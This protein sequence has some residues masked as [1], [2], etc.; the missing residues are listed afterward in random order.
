MSQSPF[1][2]N[3]STI[4][5][6]AQD[7]EDSFWKNLHSETTTT[8]Q[9]LRKRVEPAA[10]KTPVKEVEVVMR[11]RPSQESPQVHESTFGAKSKI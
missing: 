6:V 2:P 5:K 4:I 3:K 11:N 1:P 7:D 8:Q 9:L 10:V